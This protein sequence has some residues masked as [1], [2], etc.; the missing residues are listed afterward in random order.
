[1]TDNWQSLFASGPCRVVIW[2]GQ[3]QD[4]GSKVFDQTMAPGDSASIDAGM[5]LSAPQNATISV[6]TDGAVVLDGD[7]VGGAG[8]TY[9]VAVIPDVLPTDG[10]RVRSLDSAA[11]S[12]P[13]VPISICIAGAPSEQSLIDRTDVTWLDGTPPHDGPYDLTYIDDPKTV[14]VLAV[15]DVSGF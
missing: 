1:M 5:N 6:G 4:S 10:L 9:S 8:A 12:E 7:P 13:S 15:A 11:S 2:G 3:D 14:G